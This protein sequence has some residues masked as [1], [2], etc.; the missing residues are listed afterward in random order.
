M[1][2]GHN[3]MVVVEGGGGERREGG[4]QMEGEGSEERGGR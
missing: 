1:C 4:G 3:I 2:I